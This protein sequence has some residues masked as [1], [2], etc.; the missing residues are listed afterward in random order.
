MHVSWLQ[1]EVTLGAR[2]VELKFEIVVPL[3]DGSR[4][5]ALL[6]N[7]LS[8][9]GKRDPKRRFSRSIRILVMLLRGVI[10]RP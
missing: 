9:H 7:R 10:K 6:E 8:R 5:A 3:C 2:P 4:V 1:F